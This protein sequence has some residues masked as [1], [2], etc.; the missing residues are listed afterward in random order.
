MIEQWQIRKPELENLSKSGKGFDDKCI[1]TVDY[2]IV[3]ALIN[4]K[5]QDQKVIRHKGFNF[6]LTN[7]YEKMSI[8]DV[9][10]PIRVKQYILHDQDKNKYVL[11][12]FLKKIKFNPHSH[13]K[14]DSSTSADLKRKNR[15]LLSNNPIKGVYQLAYSDDIETRCFF[16]VDKNGNANGWV[17][18]I[19]YKTKNAFKTLQSINK[20]QLIDFTQSVRLY[21]V[22]DGFRKGMCIKSSN[23]KIEVK[24]NKKV[25]NLI[26]YSKK[27]EKLMGQDF[28]NQVTKLAKFGF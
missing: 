26:D 6:K 13:S 19:N 27:V 11:D 9:D 17:L 16:Q 22:R 23:E 14:F 12:L 18:E 5:P 3:Q 25:T 28:I 2:F 21:E 7:Y 20:G 10:D 15:E 24:V 4:T 1:S 8:F